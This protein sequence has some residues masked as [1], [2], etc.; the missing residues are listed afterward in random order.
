M[1][2]IHGSRRDFL[3]ISAIAGGGLLLQAALPRF[4]VSAGSQ[5]A[6]LNAFIRITPDNP[7]TIMSKNPE[8]GQ[9]IKTM[10]PMLIADELDVD[11]KNVRI[12]QADL[13][14]AKYG[15]Q[16]A[17]GSMATPLN[18]LP[19]RRVGAAGRQ[20][21]IAAAADTWNVP[22]PECTTSSGT[23]RH[24]S[25][26]RSLTYGELA[27]KAAS[28][29]S[30]NLATVKLKDPSEFKIIG[31]PLHGVDSPRIVK[32]QPIFGID[33]K[34]P[35][36]RYAVFHKCPVF[37]GKIVSANTDAIKSLLGGR[38]AFIV[39]GG[40]HMSGLHDGVAI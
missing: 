30:P 32:G 4:A 27:A 13:D 12:E 17:G 25:S 6:T 39:H 38:D 31:Q 23:V 40:D 16:F 19:L 9:G 3:K 20:M 8:I 29:P 2:A 1:R 10:L 33:V 5:P 24:A 36:M 11:W 37:G 34:V 18:W 14:T 21:M 35:G 22:A 15:R 26:N 7:V 28:L